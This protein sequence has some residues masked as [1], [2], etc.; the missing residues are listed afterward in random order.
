SSNGKAD[1][2]QIVVTASAPQSPSG[3]Y[4]N[5]PASYTASSEID[6]S[7]T[8][9]SGGNDGRDTPIP[10]APA[11]WNQIYY[12]TNWQRANDPSAPQS[13]PSIWQGTWKPGSYGGG[14]IGSGDG[15]GIGNVFYAA[16]KNLT[17]MYVSARV[18]FDFDASQWHP[19]S[20]KFF[21]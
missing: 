4:P 2:A 8:P 11:G 18:Y 6:F 17:H 5:R 15:H 19:I 21:N 7:Q 14:V 16:P 20:N 12:G 13:A 3:L 10:G 1:T 9:A